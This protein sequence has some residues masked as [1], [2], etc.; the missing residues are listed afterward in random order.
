MKTLKPTLQCVVPLILKHI[1]SCMM[2]ISFIYNTINSDFKLFTI[3]LVCYRTLC[4]GLYFASPAIKVSSLHPL[5]FEN[6]GLFN[7]NER[8]LIS[9]ARPR[10]RRRLSR[11]LPARSRRRVSAA[12]R[13]VRQGAAVSRSEAAPL[14]LHRR[15]ENTTRWR[16]RIAAL[17]WRRGS[18][19]PA[20]FQY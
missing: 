5:I 3:I 18:A 15:E 17:L 12:A 9:A 1:F 19:R 4:P 20:N 13:R 11:P 7:W 16:F 14:P 2:L 10:H 6:K 8:R